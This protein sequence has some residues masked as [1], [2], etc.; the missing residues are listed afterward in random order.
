MLA[1]SLIFGSPGESRITRTEIMI[2]ESVSVRVFKVGMLG[3]GSG[4]ADVKVHSSSFIADADAGVGAGTVAGAGASA[5]AVVGTGVCWTLVGAER[6]K[7]EDE[8]VEARCCC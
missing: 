3:E 8:G 4:R 1:L 6:S 2:V 5:V 7:S